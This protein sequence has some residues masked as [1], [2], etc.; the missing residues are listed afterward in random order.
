LNQCD[1]FFIDRGR[2]SAKTDYAVNASRPM[3]TK[4]TKMGHLIESIK[5]LGYPSFEV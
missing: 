4:S 1:E 5:T 2:T 3:A